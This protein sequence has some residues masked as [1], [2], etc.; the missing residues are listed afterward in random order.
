MK[1]LTAKEVEAVSGGADRLPVHS[2]TVESR[3]K[4]P[5]SG[6]VPSDGTVP[7]VRYVQK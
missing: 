4:N 3:G 6:P 1:E 5:F 2:G 7:Y